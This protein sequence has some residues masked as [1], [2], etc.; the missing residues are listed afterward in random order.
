MSEIREIVVVH[1]G[2]EISGFQNPVG[3][4]PFPNGNLKNM[5]G[6]FSSGAM[7]PFS[8]GPEQ[9]TNKDEKKILEF[10]L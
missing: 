8:Q 3:L 9:K 5:A 4:V 2:F 7:V 10:H 1:A 6:L